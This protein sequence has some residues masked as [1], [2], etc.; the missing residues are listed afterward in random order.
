MDLNKLTLKSQAALQAATEQ[1]RA[2]NHQL[3]E[4]AHLLFALLSDPEG[5][6][7]PILHRLGQ[8]PRTLRGRDEQLLDRIPKVYGGAGDPYLSEPLRNVLEA[9]FGEA[10]S[11]G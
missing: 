7:F 8:S 4:P 1:A 10:S 5:V 9:A 2:R 3:V 6:I 11:L